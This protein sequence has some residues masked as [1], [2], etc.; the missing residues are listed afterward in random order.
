MSDNNNRSIVICI[1]R[2]HRNG[3]VKRATTKAMSARD[4]VMCR[5]HCRYDN[6]DRRKGGWTHSATGKILNNDRDKLEITGVV[7]SLH[8]DLNIK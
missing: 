7:Q 4:R 8:P 2:G 3:K 1:V 6:D 5:L